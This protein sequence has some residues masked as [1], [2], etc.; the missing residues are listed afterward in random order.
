MDRAGGDAGMA[1]NKQ[2]MIALER[3]PAETQTRRTFYISM[4]YGL[5]G[6]ITAALGVPAFVYLFLP[7]KVKKEPDWV[8][9]GDVTRLQP[10]LPVE[11]VF[12]RNRKDGWK[13][14]SEKTTAWVVKLADNQIVAYG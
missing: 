5:W 3:P 1:S 2:P 12:R 10:K 13:I 8:E 14:I 7:P 9:I 11:M 4:I 6:L